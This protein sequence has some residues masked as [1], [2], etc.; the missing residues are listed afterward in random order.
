[1]SFAFS[2]ISKEIMW[3]GILFPYFRKPLT[4]C[5]VYPSMERSIFICDGVE[6]IFADSLSRP[7]IL[8]NSLAITCHGKLRR[9]RTNIGGKRAIGLFE[10]LLHNDDEVK[11]SP[12]HDDSLSNDKWWSML[13]IFLVLVESPETD[14]GFFVGLS[15]FRAFFVGTSEIGETLPLF[16]LFRPPL[17]IVGLR[18]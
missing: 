7:S 3:I 5:G 14:G 15:L 6:V 4:S 12:E 18:S 16:F 10:L 9:V 13:V 17:P 1:M 8:N 11:D 2:V